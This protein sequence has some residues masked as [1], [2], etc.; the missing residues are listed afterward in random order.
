MR[1]VVENFGPVVRGDVELG[2]FTVFIGP[3]NTGKSTVSQLAYL[4]RKTFV[5]D[6]PTAVLRAVFEIT[7]R[8]KSVREV[9]E[10]LS[11]IDA[12]EVLKHIDFGEL[13]GRF[14]PPHMWVNIN[15]DHAVVEWHDE[16]VDLRLRIEKDDVKVVE[17]R[18][19]ERLASHIARDMKKIVELMVGRRRL[20]VSRSN[21][22][23]PAGRPGLID[24]YISWDINVL[25]PG[26]RRRVP[27]VVE[28]FYDLLAEVGGR[29]GPLADVAGLLK[30]VMEGDVALELR[31]FVY[32][33]GGLEIRLEHAASV[34]KELAP[35]YLVVRELAKPGDFMVIEEPEAHL[36]PEAQV[37][38]VEAFA[39]LVDAG[40]RLLVTTQSDIFLRKLMHLMLRGDL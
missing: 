31:S 12:A 30:D 1:L 28:E 11:E 18:P 6:L 2:P 19:T 34:V 21:F 3:N 9:I 36:H 24:S 13:L 27:G 17:L 29:R 7:E 22:Y 4:L 15:A 37:R 14:F 26:R 32:R 16:Y 40:L 23:L 20:Y 39:K 5:D 38:V 8:G 25:L 33:R 10:R 35:V